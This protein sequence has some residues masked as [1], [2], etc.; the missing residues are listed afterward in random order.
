M[1]CAEYRERDVLG[2]QQSR[3]ARYWR[4]CGQI[5]PYNFQHQ[6]WSV[7]NAVAGRALQDVFMKIKVID[8][9]TQKASLRR[10]DFRDYQSVLSFSQDFPLSLWLQGAS[11]PVQC[12]QTVLSSA[13][14]IM[15]T[16]S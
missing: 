2:S 14:A 8:K 7:L 4:H 12:S 16:G 10:N 1:R 15:E 5:R 3:P 6:L 11:I 13:G 9:W